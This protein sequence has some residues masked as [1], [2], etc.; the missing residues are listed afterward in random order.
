MKISCLTLS[1]NQGNFLQ[2]AISSIISQEIDFEYIVYDPGS[3]DDSRSI[4]KRYSGESVRV[5]LVDGDQGPAD[6]LNRGLKEL[7]GDVFYYLNA[8]D[9]VKSN[10]FEYVIKYFSDHPECDVLH[11][12]IDIMDE[13]GEYVRTLP[14][15]KFSLLGYALGFAVVY[16]QATF[17]RMRVLK[18][19]PFNRENRICWDGELIVDLALAGAVIHQTQRVLGNFR[20][21]SE[22]ITGSGKFKKMAKNEHSRIA[23]KILGHRLRPWEKIFGTLIRYFR[24]ICRRLFPKIY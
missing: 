23:F 15:M 10:A 20:I 21:Y 11:G 18:N 2:S 13:Q 4:A 5:M 14:A 7:N 17:I 19:E 9:T 1:F 22:S 3:S 16:Q 8:D 24:A 6:G 12:S